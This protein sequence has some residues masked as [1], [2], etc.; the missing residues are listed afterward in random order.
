M[1]WGLLAGQPRIAP[2]FWSFKNDSC[3]YQ[4][5]LQIDHFFEIQEGGHFEDFGGFKDS[6]VYEAKIMNFHMKYVAPDALGLVGWP[7]SDCSKIMELQKR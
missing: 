7:A 5:S 6:L 3:P 2:K 4:F 1:H